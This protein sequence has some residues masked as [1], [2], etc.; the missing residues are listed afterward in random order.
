[1]RQR[2]QLNLCGL[3]KTKFQKNITEKSAQKGPVKCII[4]NFV[5]EIG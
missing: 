5:I 3:A 2:R 1:M 4:Y